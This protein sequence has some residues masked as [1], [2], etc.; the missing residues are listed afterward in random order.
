MGLEILERRN[1]LFGE[2]D[3]K[4]SHGFLYTMEHWAK[5]E[6]MCEEYDWV[7][8]IDLFLP[9][10]VLT[11]HTLGS[12]ELLTNSGLWSGWSS[13]EWKLF[14]VKLEGFS[15]WLLREH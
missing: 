12:V 1:F 3:Q 7:K 15:S 8:Y 11:F 6:K 5:K 4:R 2:Q 14:M 9:R 13:S 10:H